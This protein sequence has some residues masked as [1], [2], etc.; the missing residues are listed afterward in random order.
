[1]LWCNMCFTIYMY[2]VGVVGI[3][4]R[5]RVVWSGVRIVV[6]ARDFPLF[7]YVQT[8]TEVRPASCSIGTVFFLGEEVKRPG[9]KVNH[10]LP[11]SAFVAWVALAVP[12]L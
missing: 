10:P 7:H 9:R 1:M 6:G 8:D 11:S 2:R 12:S 4:P 5:L 3:M